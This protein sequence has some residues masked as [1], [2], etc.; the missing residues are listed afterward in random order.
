MSIQKEISELGN[1]VA[2]STGNESDF[3]GGT[4]V[5]TL[6]SAPAV[7][8]LVETKTPSIFDNSAAQPGDAFFQGDLILLV[9]DEFP[10]D[11]VVPSKTAQLA[12]G[13]TKGSRHI[14]T[15]GKV[16]VAEPNCREK[17]QNLIEAT[18]RR[19]NPKCKNFKLEGPEKFM[20]LGPVV[21]ADTD[22]CNVTHPQHP[23]QRFAKG[24]TFATIFQR[25]LS[26]EGRAIRARD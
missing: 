19:H 9:L 11:L 22:R 24:V 7:P 2:W 1:K 16:F 20:W 14:V 10:K 6:P 26:A 4:A 12:E 21:L 25:N 5:Q 17:L 8:P 13:D 15:G 3:T 18:V 23:W